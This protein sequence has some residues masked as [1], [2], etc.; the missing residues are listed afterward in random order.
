MCSGGNGDQVCT[1]MES[2]EGGALQGPH[3]GGGA[4]PQHNRVGPVEPQHYV[5]LILKSILSNEYIHLQ[6]FYSFSVMN[7]CGAFVD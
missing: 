5:S 4:Q 6:W 3:E 2:W 7:L 1:D